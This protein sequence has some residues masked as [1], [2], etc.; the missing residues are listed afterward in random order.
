MVES[1]GRK[2]RAMHMYRTI[3]AR[4][5]TDSS[6]WNA[7][8]L[9]RDADGCGDREQKLVIF[10]AVESVVKGGAGE[11]GR[12]DDFGIDARGKTD[13]PEVER[14]AVAEIDG[15][16]G[17]ELLAQKAS[18][19]EARFG[20]EM[21]LPGF[22]FISFEAEGGPA[23]SAGDVDGVAW[24]RA[25][26]KERAAARDGAAEGDVA[27]ERIRVREIAAGEDGSG[28]AG[29]IEDGV[30]ELINP[31]GGGPARNARGKRDRSAGIRPWRRCR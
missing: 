17:A 19:R 8:E 9:G 4:N 13:A 5:G 3:T 12:F 15:G 16:G 6:E 25:G 21:P 27:G 7:F 22:T 31:S 26:A 11:A 24:T 18:E 1:E 23:E 20:I 10:A 30:E 14:E 28:G 2:R 29:E